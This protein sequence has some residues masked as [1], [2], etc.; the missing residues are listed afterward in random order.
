MPAIE[1]DGNWRSAPS[2]CALAAT[3]RDGG[4]ADNPVGPL[5]DHD[6]PIVLIRYTGWVTSSIGERFATL[7]TDAGVDISQAVVLSHRA[8]SAA[9]AVGAGVPN[10]QSNVMQLAT[11]CLRLA[12]DRTDPRK[13]QREFDRIQRLLLKVLKAE[14]VGHSTER[15][16][17]LSNVSIDWLRRSTVQL[18][19]AVG[20]HDL[21]LNVPDWV[22]AARKSMKAIADTEG[23]TYMALGTLFPT[24]QNSAGKNMRSLLNAQV[25]AVALRHSSIH[26]AKGSEHRAVLVVVPR[27]RAAVTRTAEVTTA[28]E[29]GAACEAKR[30]LY[31]GVTRAEQ[32]CALAV[33]D[34]IADRILAIL[35]AEGVPFTIHTV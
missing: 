19:I 22:A 15:S 17:E 23:R 6:Q 25:G 11:A 27:D 30:V 13:R 32:I 5:A 33:P 24:P 28:W 18:A 3:L 14:V 34:G 26:K 10:G 31:V 16:A 12:D 7:V 35:T 9:A 20:G 29:Q 8:N 1:L 4:P 21:D 2:V